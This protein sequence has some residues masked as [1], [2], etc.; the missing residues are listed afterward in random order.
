MMNDFQ[1]LQKA[2]ELV[3]KGFWVYPLS[4]NSKGGLKGSHG[5]NDMTNNPEKVKELFQ[6][7]PKANL[8]IS[9]RHSNLIVLDVDNHDNQKG[10]HSLKKLAAQ[11]LKVPNDTYIETTPHGIHY[12]FRHNTTTKNVSSAFFTGSGL[13]I[14]TDHII[15]TPSVVKGRE[16]KSIND[17]T[18][19]KP[20]P[21][22]LVDELEKTK[23]ESKSRS[24]FRRAKPRT[25]G[26]LAITLEY[27]TNGAD[28]G[29][30]NN[31]FASLIGRLLAGGTDLTVAYNVAL[32]A[33][34]N[35]VNP[36]LDEDELN[37]IFKSI[38]ERDQ[39]N[40]REKRGDCS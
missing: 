7:Q 27:M 16:Y 25:K 14:K 31:Y 15:V 39:H 13:E 30:R 22:W 18:D 29:N 33:N 21:Q 11:G 3:R 5:F 35:F 20:A 6:N 32:V 12:F 36:S 2:L 28:E 9:L 26:N 4:P 40:Q 24:K 19:L 10:T 38:L 8:G 23:P 17:F 34:E 37:T 1:T